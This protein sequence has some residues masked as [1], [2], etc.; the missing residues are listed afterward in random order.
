MH[1][2]VASHFGPMFL[3]VFP[4]GCS[5]PANAITEVMSFFMVMSPFNTLSAKEVGFVFS[6]TRAIPTR[7]N[8][9]VQE[10]TTVYTE[11]TALDLPVTAESLGGRNSYYFLS[12]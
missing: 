7:E 1:E 3:N 8:A 10:T 11:I 5:E 12:L 2:T 4:A 6:K 9:S